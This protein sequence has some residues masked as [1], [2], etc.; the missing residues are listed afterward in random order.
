MQ[1]V[2]R[3]GQETDYTYDALNRETAEEWVNS[4]GSVFRTIAT[5]YYANGLTE[6]VTDSGDTNGQYLDYSYTYDSIGE[7]LTVDATGPSGTTSTVLTNG[8]DQDGD[9]TSLAANIGGTVTGANN[10][11]GGS[12][13]G[14]TNDFLNNYTYDDLDQMI[15]VTQG[16]N[17]GNTVSPKSAAFGYDY[18]G[19]FTAINL[20]A[21]AN[22]HTAASTDTTDRVARAVYGY[23]GD[24]RLT[25]LAYTLPSGSSGTAPSYEWTYDGA[26]RVTKQYSMAD[27]SGS[28]DP[29]TYTTW[30]SAS[31]NYDAAGQL[32][33]N[34]STPAV[35]V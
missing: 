23:D 3:D 18:D 14:G 10:G 5:N 17:G 7:L 8:Y 16:G 13:S 12:V 21:D 26:N 34:G 15:E 28:Y 29:G 2:D 6:S 4:S 19:E 30:A 33:T 25:S 31:Y 22:T 24:G 11:I 1:S 9:R 32:A 35:T 20:Y 27:T